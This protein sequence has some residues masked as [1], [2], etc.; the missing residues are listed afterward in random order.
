MTNTLPVHGPAPTSSTG[1]LLGQSRR[2]GQPIMLEDPSR[3]QATYLLGK[4]GMGKTTLLLHCILH[5]LARGT[6]FCLIDAHG[7]LTDAVLKRVRQEH[8]ERVF[9]VELDP[10]RPFGLNLFD[11]SDRDDPAQVDRAV[12]HVV[13]VFKKIWGDSSWGARLEDLL[14]NTAHTFIENPGMTLAEVPKFLSDAAFRHRLVRNVTNPV[15]RDYWCDEYDHLSPGQQQ[16]YRAPV[17]NKVRAFLRNHLLYR[18]LSQ[19]QTTLNFRE[20]MDAG[21][22]LL[23][24]LPVG[25]LGEGVVQFLGSLLLGQLLHAAYSRI[26]LPEDQRR[27]F[28][29]YCD[30]Y[31]LFCTPSTADLLTGGRKFGVGTLV[32]HQVREQ[33]DAAN[34]AATLNAANLVLFQLIGD[35]ARELAKNL[36]G[37]GQLVRVGERPK[38]VLAPAP[39]TYVAR[40]GHPNSDVVTAVHKLEAL[41]QERALWIKRQRYIWSKEEAY[42]AIDRYLHAALTSKGAAQHIPEPLLPGVLAFM[43]YSGE[44]ERVNWGEHYDAL[45]PAQQDT[46]REAVERLQNAETR[47]YEL[48]QE[49]AAALVCPLGPKQAPVSVP[50]IAVLA[51]EVFPGLWREPVY[52]NSGQYEPE[53]K[54]RPIAEEL[55]ALPPYHAHT[56]LREGKAIVE[57]TIT[58]HKPGDV[59]LTP[60]V[61]VRIELIKACSRSRLCRRWEEVECVIERRPEGMQDGQ[62]ADHRQQHPESQAPPRS[63]PL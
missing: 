11:C 19:S 46:F 55:V 25:K 37:K 59:P 48:L 3:L 50:E 6:G 23:I 40:H 26:E 36:N 56:K 53:Y 49:I 30:E 20:A 31:Q 63:E 13:Q 29:L 27:P 44:A 28:H 18:V 4:T 14:S 22:G 62:A 38:R 42:D 16:Q 17:L 35:D 57:H 39:F 12:D 8:T 61:A 33:L 52:V 9:M 2:T 43:G 51:H 21:H 54:E 5:D 1:V 10:E 41:I 7:D 60:E 24:T 47:R 34:K 15:V 45:N 32:A 58:T